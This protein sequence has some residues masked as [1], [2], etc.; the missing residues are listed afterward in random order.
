MSL[1]YTSVDHIDP[2]STPILLNASLLKISACQFRMYLA[3]MRGYKLKVDPEIPAAGTALHKFCSVKDITGDHGIAV[4]EAMKIAPD[5]SKLRATLM[6]LMACKQPGRPPIIGKNGE[7]FVE[8]EL[9]IPWRRYVYDGNDF[10]IVLKGTLDRITCQSDILIVEDY[11]TSHY[12]K[13]EDALRKYEYEIQ[14]EFYKWLC[15]EFGH[16]FLPTPLANLAR[17]CKIMSQVIVAK[18]CSSP[19][20]VYGPQRGFTPRKAELIVELLDEFIEHRLLPMYTATYIPQD[21]MLTNSCLYCD[22]KHACHAGDEAM[23]N[24][25]MSANFEIKPQ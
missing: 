24:T 20:W 1:A 13:D 5:N 23:F 16:M 21:G 7:L 19:R 15:Y 25:I 11:K 3:N 6:A 4:A 22:F 10:T 9:R 8:Q 12:F 17:Q 18:M 2:A 14:F